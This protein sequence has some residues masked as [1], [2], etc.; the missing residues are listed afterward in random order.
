M[1][2]RGVPSST[3]RTSVVLLPLCSWFTTASGHNKSQRS[4]STDPHNITLSG[5]SVIVL[6][7][8]RGHTGKLFEDEATEIVYRIRLKLSSNL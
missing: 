3:N 5:T 2:N 7:S 4:E 1:R 6:E 8:I